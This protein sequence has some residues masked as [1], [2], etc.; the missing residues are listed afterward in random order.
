MAVLQK[1]QISKSRKKLVPSLSGS[2]AEDE[3]AKRAN[4]VSALAKPRLSPS[5]APSPTTDEPDQLFR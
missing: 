1:C 2:H 3:N 4:S 5:L